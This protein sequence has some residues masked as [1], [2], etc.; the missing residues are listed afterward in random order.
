MNPLAL[1]IVHR[2]APVV[3]EIWIQA[4]VWEGAVRADV[5]SEQLVSFTEVVIDSCN[6]LT[7]RK[8]TRRCAR[9]V[10]GAGSV[11]LRHVSVDQLL[12]NGID[13]ALGNDIV[14]E[15]STRGTEWIANGRGR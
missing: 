2:I 10:Y 15:D 5:V 3:A 4:E 1:D 14:G 12:R 9:V 6:A 11:R 8:V 7:H 13:P